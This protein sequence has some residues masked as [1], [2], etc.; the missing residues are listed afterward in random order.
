MTTK[1]VQLRRGSDSDHDS[2]T[3]AIGELTYVSDD[4]TLRIHDAST[5]GGVKVITE[6]TGTTNIS[7]D[8]AVNTDK[9]T[10]DS[11]TGNTVVAGTLD[12]TGITSLTTDLTVNTDKMTVDGATGNTVIAGTL[13]VTG[14]TSL[15]TDLTVNTDKMTV[16]G[17]TGDT[18]VAGTLDVTGNTTLTAILLTE[19]SAD[20]GDPTEGSTVIWMSDGTEAGDDGD[21]MVKITAGATTNTF[22]LVDF[23]A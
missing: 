9:M 7:N 13:G 20:P 23:D 14:V 19:K 2:F 17:A 22:T 16:D 10:V 4:K 21:I 15:T 18:A 8:V 1:Q 3:G 12:V 11:A 6:G 5:A